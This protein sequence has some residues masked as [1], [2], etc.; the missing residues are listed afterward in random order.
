M[1]KNDFNDA[2]KIIEGEVIVIPQKNI[3]EYKKNELIKKWKNY[4]K[5]KNKRIIYT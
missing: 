4:N 2:S 3:N 1:Y 5:D